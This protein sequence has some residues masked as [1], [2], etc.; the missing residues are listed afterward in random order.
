MDV[1]RRKSPGESGGDFHRGLVGLDLEEVVAGLHHVACVFEPFG[2]LPLGD[3]F[4]ELGHQDVHLVLLRYHTTDTYQFSR[5]SINP[6]CPPSPPNPD[7]YIPPTPPP[8]PAT[9]PRSTPL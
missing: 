6:P 1:D 2:D 8:P 5:N 3:G 7:S 4:A 9:P